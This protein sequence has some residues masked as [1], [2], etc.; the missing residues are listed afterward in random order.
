MRTE[1]TQPVVRVQKVCL[2][3]AC[4]GLRVKEK[5]QSARLAAVAGRIDG[6]IIFDSLVLAFGPGNRAAQDNTEGPEGD[7]GHPTAEVWP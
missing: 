3:T 4:T 7:V 1:N 5:H 6:E 2:V